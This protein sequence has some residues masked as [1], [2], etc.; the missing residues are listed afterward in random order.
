MG[1]HTSGGTAA[2]EGGTVLFWLFEKPQNCI[3]YHHPKNTKLCL[4][5]G[6]QFWRGLG[7]KLFHTTHNKLFCHDENSIG[8]RPDLNS[9]CEKNIQAK[10]RKYD[11]HPKNTKKKIGRQVVVWPIDHG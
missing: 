5:F 9:A 11:S 6:G 3:F 4:W 10:I 1:G 2:S 8:L 7:P